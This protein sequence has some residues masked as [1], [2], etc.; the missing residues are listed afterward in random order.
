MKYG[1]T[2]LSMRRTAKMDLEPAMTRPAKER[3][4]RGSWRD[5]K[6]R[7]K[8]GM[9]GISMLTFWTVFA[10]SIGISRRERSVGLVKLSAK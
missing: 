6:K 3:R 8:L 7:G 4:R 9:R 5:Q 10:S 2:K 1:V